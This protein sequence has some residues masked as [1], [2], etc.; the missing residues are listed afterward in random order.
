[1]IV[2]KILLPPLQVLKSSNDSSAFA[3]CYHLQ[4]YC[5]YLVGKPKFQHQICSILINV[6]NYF[7][8]YTKL[9]TVPI[10]DAHRKN[11]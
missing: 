8:H 10:F 1:M 2:F 5:G 3:R 9:V 7:D 11:N 4:M 6:Q